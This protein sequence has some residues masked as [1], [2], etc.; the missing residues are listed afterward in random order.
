MDAMDA[1]AMGVDAIFGKGKAQEAQQRRGGILLK[2]FELINGERQD[3]H[4]APEDNFR[5]I[6]QLWSVWLGMSL[7]ERDVA[8][9]MTLLKL[10]RVKSGTA[11][12]DSY[13][14]ALGYLALGHDFEVARREA[15]EDGE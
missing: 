12:E 7:R 14:D 6:A 5:R 10:A 9:M 13:C 1:M 4:G 3:Q 11:F 15:L 2:A 8:V